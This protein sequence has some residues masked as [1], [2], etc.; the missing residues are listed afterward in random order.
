MPLSTLIE[1]TVAPHRDFGIAIKVR[2]ALAQD[3]EPVGMRNPAIFTASAT[4][5]RTRS[6]SRASASK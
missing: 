6:I 5:W 4:F 3:A 2:I 1:E